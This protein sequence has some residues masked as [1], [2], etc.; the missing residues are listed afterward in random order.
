MRSYSTYLLAALLLA[1]VAISIGF[2]YSEG[3]TYHKTISS[4]N[5]REVKATIEAGFAKVFISSGK[6]E[7]ILDADITSEKTLNISNCIDYSVRDKVGYLTMNTEEHHGEDGHGVHISG[8]ESSTWNTTFTGAVPISFDIELGLGKGD[9]DFTGIDVKDLSIST[10]ASSVRMHFDKP[11]KHV[12]ENLTIEAGLSKFESKGLGNARF[13]RLK[14]EGGVGSYLLDFSGKFDQ[15]AD[16]DI[17]VGLGSLTVII[18]K[19]TGVKLTAEKN[20][21]THFDIDDDLSDQGNDSYLSSNYD[22]AVGKLNLHIDAGVGSV[23]IRRE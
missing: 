19:N 9:F 8:F 12:I 15:E 4:T 2:V 23:K 11:N 14:F 10:G 21:I 7:T 3:K 5:E 1:A 13:K 17:E 18:P 20:F 6:A 22:S 16:V